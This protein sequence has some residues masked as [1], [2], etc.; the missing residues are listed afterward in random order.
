M[1]ILRSQDILVKLVGQSLRISLV[2]G[3]QVLQMEKFVHIQVGRKQPDAAIGEPGNGPGNRNGKG[4]RSF[5]KV[6]GELHRIV[7]GK[8]AV[9]LEK[10]SQIAHVPDLSECCPVVVLDEGRGLEFNASIFSPFGTTNRSD[11]N[12]LIHMAP[13]S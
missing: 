2:E 10:R 5:Q 4:G 8:L 1:I 11:F 9:G 13:V 7:N 12:D 6:D 3:K